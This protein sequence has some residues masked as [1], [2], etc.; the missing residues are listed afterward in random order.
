MV[1]AVIPSAIGSHCI[2]LHFS[3][4][5]CTILTPFLLRLR[6][7]ST[8]DNKDLTYFCTIHGRSQSAKAT[9]ART[10]PGERFRSSGKFQLVDCS[11]ITAGIE[12]TRF[13]YD[14]LEKRIG[15]LASTINSHFYLSS[16]ELVAI[17]AS[18]NLKYSK[19]SGSASAVG[20]SFG[21][22][23]YYRIS[24]RNARRINQKVSNSSS[25]LYSGLCYL[26]DLRLVCKVTLIES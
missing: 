1:S 23:R 15:N 16:L 11:E 24:Q 26:C 25:F 9:T 22:F 2:F 6:D 14:R 21:A 13:F 7:L 8:H 10:K 3:F 19:Q 12:K 17:T 18:F 5:Q 4:V 20:C